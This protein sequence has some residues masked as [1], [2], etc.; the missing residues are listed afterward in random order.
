M[1]PP[2]LM[3]R[4]TNG[5]KAGVSKK[6]MLA[7]TSKNYD[8]LPEVK[9]RKEDERKK[10]EMKNRMQQVKELENKRRELMRRK[11]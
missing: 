3:N 2:A 5:S 8:L 10:L 1:P 7:L 4:L 11:Q 9:Q 6:D